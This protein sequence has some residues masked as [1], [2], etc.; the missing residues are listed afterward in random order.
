MCHF[1]IAEPDETRLKTLS[2]ALNCVDTGIILLNRDMRVRFTNNRVQELFDLPPAILATG[3]HYRELVAFAAVNG[4]FAVPADQLEDYIAQ[5]VD[6]VQAGSVPPTRIDLTND[7]RVLFSCKTCSDGGRVLTYADISQELYRE[8]RDATERISAELRFRTEVLE[9]QGAYLASLAE[10]ADDSIRKAEMA[11][12][13]LENEI[14]ERRRLEM[15]LRRLASTD[16]LTGILNRSAF[17]A[18]GQRE[19]EWVRPIGQVV[20]LLMV[21]VDHFKA[22]NDRYGHAGGDLG[23]QHLVATLRSGLRESDLLGRLGG[24]EFAIVLHTGSPE[25]AEGIAERLRS[26]VEAERLTF[27]DRVIQM[28]ISVGFA[29]R[30]PAD[31]SIDQLIARADAALYEAKHSGR[32]R[33]IKDRTSVA[34]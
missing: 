28:T 25:I 2:D 10:A 29:V 30:Q 20:V 6:A 4:R 27:N 14:A 19:M 17:L 9:D 31:H 12:L 24:E 21:D 32:N 34:T 13:E 1:L 5:R 15:D 16:G 7:M 11:R 26:R 23:L 22:I 18:A 3:P 8:A 33:V